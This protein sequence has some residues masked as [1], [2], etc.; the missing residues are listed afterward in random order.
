ML[1]KKK[2]YAVVKR[3]MPQMPAKLNQ[4]KEAGVKTDNKKEGLEE[5]KNEEV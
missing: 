5:R 4:Q 2:R 1:F 3:P